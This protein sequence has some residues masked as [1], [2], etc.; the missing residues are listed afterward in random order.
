MYPPPKAGGS[1]AKNLCDKLNLISFLLPYPWKVCKIFRLELIGLYTPSLFFKLLLHK[2]LIKTTFNHILL[3]F[4]FGEPMKRLY[5]ILVTFLFIINSPLLSSASAGSHKIVL[6]EEATNAYCDP[7]AQLNPGFQEMY[8]NHFG[9]LV[10]VRYH[11]WWPGSA[12]PMYQSNTQDNYDRIVYYSVGGVPT[13]M[14]D[15]IY[16][17]N[18]YNPAK[19]ESEMYERLSHSSPVQID[20]R[21]QQEKDSLKT[22]VVLRALEMLEAD[23]LFLRVAIIERHVVYAYPPGSNGE[24][25]FASV[26]R[27]MLPDARGTACG[28]MVESDSL[29]LSFSLPLQAD[30]NPDDLAVVAWL[31]DDHTKEV[32]QAN[33]DFPTFILQEQESHLQILP[34]DT[35]VL[36]EYFIANDNDQPLS[37]QIE[38]RNIN[39][40]QD[41]QLI[42]VL[43]ESKTSQSTFEIAAGDTLR[44]YLQ[45]QSTAGG[46]AEA[47]VFAKNLSDPGFYGEGYGYGFA[48]NFRA[49]VAENNEV[50]LVDDDGSMSFE[51][52]F[53][54]VLHELN[55]AFIT[56]AQSD[57]SYFKSQVDLNAYR[58]IIWNCSASVPAFSEEEISML[59]EYLDEGGNLLLFGQDIASDIFEENGLSNFNSAQDFFNKYLGATYLEENPAALSVRG[60]DGD[61]L[62]DGISFSLASP[63]GFGYNQPDAILPDTI[64]S[65]PVFHY[66]N[67]KIAAVRKDSAGFKTVYFAFGLEQVN[68]HTQRSLILRR[69]LAWAGNVT[70]LNSSRPIHPQQ[71]RLSN[72]YPNPFGGAASFGADSR[73]NFTVF[74]PASAVMQLQVYD[75]LGRR[76]RTLF[77]GRKNRG[78][79]HFQWDGKNDSGRYVS[80]GVYFLRLHS[81]QQI[82]QNKLLFIR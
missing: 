78:A 47:E 43:P 82:S 73:T 27:K 66:N 20:I 36:K 25:D 17:G 42:L 75:I 13:Y 31:Q 38:L 11:A 7:C 35:L 4:F 62:S 61:T 54:N 55:V 30:W 72:N 29:A 34:A 63:Y 65:F 33:I 53:E 44:F 1:G 41:W 68:S 71:M 69:A 14:L 26:M 48:R 74:L 46:S 64:C 19:I 81:G 40:P 3:I 77:S 45:T 21:Y 6:L 18:P 39:K 23:S 2:K 79:H 60:I 32:L 51:E 9:G 57:L 49:L 59:R 5:N 76:I 50:L 67:D 37:V 15:G 16:Q 22:E 56:V 28:P 70:A 10:S 58:T 52:N 80:S 12:D 24:T 8:A